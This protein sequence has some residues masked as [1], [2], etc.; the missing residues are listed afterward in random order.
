[1]RYLHRGGEH[2]QRFFGDSLL[3]AK[4]TDRTAKEAKKALCSGV[5]L[6]ALCDLCGNRFCLYLRH[7]Q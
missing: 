1:M 2:Q 5:F 7:A 3:I 6:C 4:V